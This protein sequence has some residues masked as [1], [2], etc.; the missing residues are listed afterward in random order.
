MKKNIASLDFDGTL[1]VDNMEKDCIDFLQSLPEGVIAIINT[2]RGINLLQEKVQHYFSDHYNLFMNSMNYFIC[3]NGT[4]IYYESSGE[5]ITL[6]EW[7]EYLAD[8]W[9]RNLLLERL[10]PV[11]EKL[12]FDLY[13]EDYNY[14]LLYYFL[15]PSFAEADAAIKEFK[16]AISDQQ[17]NL[18]HAESSQEPP[19]GLMK[20]VC[21]IFPKK[22]GKGNALIF[23][24][25]YLQANGQKIE[26]IA[27]FGDD[28]NDAQTIVDMPVLYDWWYGCLVGNSTDWIINK[29]NEVRDQVKGKII[30]A[31]KEYPG[32]L[33]ISWIMKE[34]GWIN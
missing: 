29:V 11:A 24:K 5:Y 8:Q 19:E 22:A 16:S 9:D 25:D 32:P 28:R 20:F 13:P 14:K 6:K 3:N 34:L 21:E 18:V 33:G 30:I 23:L 4:D 26:H 12:K 10:T 31:P 15:R 17:V 7:M 2:G 1:R 27:C